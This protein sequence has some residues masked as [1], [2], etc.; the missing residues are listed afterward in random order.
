[1]NQGRQVP[2]PAG[3][4]ASG[5]RGL[6]TLGHFGHLLARFRAAAATVR[7]LLHDRV[8]A[9]PAALALALPAHL[10]TDCAHLSVE[11]GPAK[12]EPCAGLTDLRAIVERADVSCLG[13]LAAQLETVLDGLET[14]SSR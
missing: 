3:C 8:V 7:A 2:G 4:V 13:V 12:H 9:H 11:P 14:W 6:R 5:N 1:M 10:R